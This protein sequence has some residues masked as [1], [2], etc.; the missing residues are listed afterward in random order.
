MNAC[1]S[2]LS[3]LYLRPSC[4][5]MSLSVLVPLCLCV[6]ASVGLL[7]GN[8][9]ALAARF[10]SLCPL[11]LQVNV[12]QAL[13][14]TT[15]AEALAELCLSSDVWDCLG[16]CVGDVQLQL[17]EASRAYDLVQG[18]SVVFAPPSLFYA[19]L[20]AFLPSFLPGPLRPE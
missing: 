14:P 8:R 6:C 18:I 11:P 16:R 15:D 9:F 17:I 5:P 19:S 20:S 13:F 10:H 3:H 7:L 1:P 4:L 12:P 2:R